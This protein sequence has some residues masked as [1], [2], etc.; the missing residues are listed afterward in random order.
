MVASTWKSRNCLIYNQS[1]TTLLELRI[2][3][4]VSKGPE[5][6]SR[7]QSDSGSYS[8][9]VQG[10]VR[11][12]HTPR[13]EQWKKG[14]T[15]YLLWEAVS[16]LQTKIN[17]IRR[18]PCR[19]NMSRLYRYS[20]IFQSLGTYRPSDFAEIL[21]MSFLRL[22]RMRERLTTGP[23]HDLRLLCTSEKMS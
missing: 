5:F 15:S 4:R 11:L 20:M 6:A 16:Y 10:L 3:R 8:S 17:S 12:P 23:R 14:E 13:N 1:G 19:E 9:K 22:C 7:V 2:Y 18:I 21:W